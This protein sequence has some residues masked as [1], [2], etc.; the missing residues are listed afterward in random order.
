MS[1]LVV[2]GSKNDIPKVRLLRPNKF[3]AHTMILQHILV[4]KGPTGV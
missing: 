2:G 4:R 3:G 1:R